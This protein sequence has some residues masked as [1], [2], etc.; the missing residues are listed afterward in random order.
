MDSN[1]N[2]SIITDFG[3]PFSCS[4]CVTNSQ[5]TKKKFV[6]DKDS[7]IA[8]KKI[9]NSGNFKRISISGGGEPLFIHSY[10]IEKFYTELFIISTEIGIPVHVH[11][12]MEKP[13][14]FVKLFEKVT[15]SINYKNFKEK[16]F[17][18][19]DI[20]QKRFVHVSTGKDLYIIKEMIE[21]LPEGSQFTVKQ[22]ESE[23]ISSFSEI[24]EY[25]ETVDKPVIFLKTGDYNTYFSLNDNNVYE[26]F[27][28][29][30]FK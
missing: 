9:L 11:T 12:N 15:I 28:D 8:I 24:I 10:E 7:F 30:K 14:E 4:F 27:S 23:D 26:H 13:N 1:S 16:F 17:N 6:F 18:W 21:V 19:N 5:K 22:L 25:M 3:C 20:N 2:F 29:I